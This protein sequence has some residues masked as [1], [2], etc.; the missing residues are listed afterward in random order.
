MMQNCQDA[1]AINC[2]YHD[3]DLFVTITAYPNWPEVKDK[4]LPGQS[5]SDH[6]DLIASV[7]HEKIKQIIKDIC[8]DGVM[9]RT[10]AHIYTIEFQ[11]CGL[12]HMHMIVFF[13]PDSKLCTPEDID[14]LLL[15]KFPDKETH[16]DLFNLVKKHMVHTPCRIEHDNENSPCLVD[17]KCSKQDF[18]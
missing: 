12:P 10:V 13:Y 15:A 8:T 7:F 3:A 2:Y 1:L 9:E 18:P 16:R 14:T 6:P 4:L 5:A 17:G 11:K